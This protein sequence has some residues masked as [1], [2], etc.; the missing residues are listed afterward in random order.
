MLVGFTS[1]YAIDV[2]HHFFDSRA[3]RGVLDT[4]PCDQIYQWRPE[5]H[6]VGTIPKSNIKTA[7]RGKIDTPN[8]RIYVR[9]ILKV[10]LIDKQNIAQK[11]LNDYP[12][13][14]I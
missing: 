2:Y 6:S 9:S 10:K 3:W 12:V 14:N 5:D 7:E 1:T 4:T 11:M 13:F 8:T